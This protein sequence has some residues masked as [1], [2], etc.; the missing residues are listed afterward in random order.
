MPL[1]DSISSAGTAKVPTMREIV[2]IMWEPVNRDTA[3]GIFLPRAYVRAI[4]RPPSCS[5]HRTTFVYSEH[6]FLETV[7]QT[8]A[9][10]EAMPE[11]LLLLGVQPDLLETE[12]GWIRCGTLL[13]SALAQP[14]TPSQRFSK[15]RKRRK[16]MEHPG[17]E[18]GET[19]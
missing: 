11:R 6:R 9:S 17:W 3:A 19:P 8:K 5:A 15:N 12:Y 10:V 18:A 2:P 13:N 7:W 4:L 14:S 1:Q 16:L